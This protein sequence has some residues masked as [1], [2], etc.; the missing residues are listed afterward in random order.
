MTRLPQSK[1]SRKHGEGMFGT[2][3]H[4]VSPAPM[5]LSQGLAD[6]AH[7]YDEAHAIEEGP[8]VFVSPSRYMGSPAKQ[9]CARCGVPRRSDALVDGVCRYQPKCDM[10][11]GWR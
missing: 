6:A 1:N 8:P 5:R 11:R 9:M 3:M 2:A 7:A 10:Q 4:L